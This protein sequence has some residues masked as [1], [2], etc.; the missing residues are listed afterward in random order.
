[1]LLFALREEASW[2]INSPPEPLIRRAAVGVLVALFGIHYNDI[3]SLVVDI[4]FSRPVSVSVA[5]V[6]AKAYSRGDCAAG[7]VWFEPGPEGRVCCQNRDGIFRHREDMHNQGSPLPPAVKSALE[8]LCP[9]KRQRGDERRALIRTPGGVSRVQI[10][11]RLISSV[12]WSH[13]PTSSCGR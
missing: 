8:R 3:R 5:D 1:M 2:P 10:H 12:Y 13:S 7:K 11:L 4:V 6:K 9:L